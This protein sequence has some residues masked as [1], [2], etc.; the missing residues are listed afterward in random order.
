MAK[1]SISHGFI[2]FVSAVTVLFTSCRNT[3]GT[4]ETGVTKAGAQYEIMRT[5]T[6]DTA[7]DLYVYV[8]DTA[9]LADVNTELVNQ[10]NTGN[11]QS[12]TIMYFDSRKIAERFYHKVTENPGLNDDK[13]KKFMRHRIGVYYAGKTHT[14]QLTRQYY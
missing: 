12:L 3:P 7:T 5:V 13:L 11:S 10:H 4:N 8:A 2:I 1:H 14:G 6:S 9:Q